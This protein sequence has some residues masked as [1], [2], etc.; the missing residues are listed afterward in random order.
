MCLIVVIRAK[1][2]INDNYVIILFTKV[3]TIIYI[4]GANQA[5]VPKI[6]IYRP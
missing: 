4:D 1:I 6:T 5:A 2:R 3:K